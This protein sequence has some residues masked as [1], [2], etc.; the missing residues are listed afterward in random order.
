[1]NKY[2]FIA[3][4]VIVI[5]ALGWFIFIAPKSSTPTDKVSQQSEITTAITKVA[6]GQAVLVDVRTPEEF[7]SGHAKYATNFDSVKVQNGE[8][9]PA[10][11]NAAI[12]LYCRTGHRAGQVKTILNQQG[13]TNVT[14]LGGL[15]DMQNAR[16][17]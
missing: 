13:Y 8:Q 3:I 17:F 16:A 7:N 1:M 2:I 15:T 14:S 9:F 5:G 6:S 10:D 4:T 11:K 12:Y